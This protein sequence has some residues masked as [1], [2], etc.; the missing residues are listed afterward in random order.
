MAS[1]EQVRDTFDRGG[2]GPSTHRHVPAL[3]SGW[4]AIHTSISAGFVH[5]FR[6]LDPLRQVFQ[7]LAS[8]TNQNKSSC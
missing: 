8:R 7:E 4:H 6:T 5:E 2:I 1:L 3:K